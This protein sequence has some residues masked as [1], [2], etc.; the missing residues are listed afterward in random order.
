LPN[1]KPSVLYCD[2]YRAAN[3]FGLPPPIE[4]IPKLA[5]LVHLIHTGAHASRKPSPNFFAF[6]PSAFIIQISVN[7][8]SCPRSDEYTIC[9]PSGDHDGYLI[10]DVRVLGK[11]EARPR[12]R[13][14]ELVQKNFLLAAFAILRTRERDFG[15]IGRPSR[16]ERDTA[17]KKRGSASEWEAQ[18]IL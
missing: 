11:R 5:Y 1:K 10:P 6:E 16:R 9:L 4:Q 3:D 8:A 15:T 7:N 2:S 12:I 17:R 18:I 14:G 13:L